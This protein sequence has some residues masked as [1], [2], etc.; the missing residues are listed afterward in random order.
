M[1]YRHAAGDV[2]A[3][4]PND[5]PARRLGRPRG[6]VYPQLLAVLA[7]DGGTMT[8]GEIIAEFDRRSQRNARW[9]ANESTLRSALKALVADGTLD[10]G[11]DGTGFRVAG[12]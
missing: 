11:P 10:R 2:P 3:T 4:S 7:D 6:V 9:Q 8:E 5:V 1:H 12:M